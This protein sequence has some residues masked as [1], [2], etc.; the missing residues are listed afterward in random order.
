MK[1]KILSGPHVHSGC[2]YEN[3][4]DLLKVLFRLN[5]ERVN[6]KRDFGNAIRLKKLMFLDLGQF[7]VSPIFFRNNTTFKMI[8]PIE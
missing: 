6:I 4:P 7:C 3:L 5:F 8:T 1:V 2:A